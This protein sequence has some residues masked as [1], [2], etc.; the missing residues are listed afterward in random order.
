MN[1]ALIIESLG[2]S[3]ARKAFSCGVLALDRYIREQASQDVKRRVGNCFVAVDRDAGALAGYYTLAASSIPIASLP[4]DQ[5]KR[6]PHYPI[7]PAILIGRLAVDARYQGRQVGSALIVDALRRSVGAAPAAFALIV[8]A[9][10]DQAAAFYR[11]HGFTPFLS[12]PLS[13]FL[14]IA[15][16]LK[17]FG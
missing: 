11:R 15:T 8:D 12:R 16:A 9:K 7:L 6:L 1:F 14:P 13:L 5:A 17:L 2:G 3:H 10:D 4:E